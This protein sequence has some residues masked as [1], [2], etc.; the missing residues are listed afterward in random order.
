MRNRIRPHS[1]VVLAL[2]LFALVTGSCSESSVKP[3]LSNSEPT[4]TVATAA[5]TTGAQHRDEIDE[6]FDLPPEARASNGGGDPRPPAYWAVW[7]SCAADNRAEEAAANGGRAAG[8]VLIDDL[9]TDPGLQLGDHLLTSCEESVALLNSRLATGDDTSDP[10]YALSAQLLAAELNLNV[11]AET[12]PAAEESVI[13]AHLVLASA[14]FDGVSTTPLDAEAG[15]ALPQI[16]DLLT[17]YNSGELC[18]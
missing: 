14:R 7:N 1:Q 15:G 18:R 3:P 5:S 9:L 13:G 12:C 4:S 16:I 10:A 11:G 6:R 8:W 2:L 17:A